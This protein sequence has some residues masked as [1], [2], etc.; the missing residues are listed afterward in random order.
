MI[1]VTRTMTA[2]PT[3][4]PRIAPTIPAFDDDLEE[5]INLS[6]DGVAAEIQRQT[7]PTQRMVRN[8]SP[9]STVREGSG[10]APLTEVPRPRHAR[11]LL[12]LYPAASSSQQKYPS[13]S[14][15]FH[16]EF[17][18]SRSEPQFVRG[19]QHLKA[20]FRLHVRVLGQQA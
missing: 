19:A 11:W 1:Q 20:S 3:M 7:G 5:A 17:A 16:E 10:I 14:N 9:G 8:L 18:Q 6:K 12:T 4:L 15:S 2:K 13:L